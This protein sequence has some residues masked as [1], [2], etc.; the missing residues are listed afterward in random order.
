MVT[1]PET[2]NGFLTYDSYAVEEVVNY[3]AKEIGWER[4][5]PVPGGNPRTFQERFRH[6]DVQHHA[7]R[8]GYHE[9]EIGF[10]KVLARGGGGGGGG[11]APFNA[12]LDVNSL[13]H[14]VLHYA[15]PDSGTNHG[16]AM[17]MQCAELLGYTTR[18]QIRLV[19]G[20][21]ELTPSA[22]GWNSGLTTQ[23]Q[24]GALLNAAEKMKK[25]LVARAADGFEG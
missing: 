13:G 18:D 14:V 10:E 3:G 4:R 8:V 9:G 15:Q 21:S 1:M 6:C 12:V 25:D 17:A 19:W 5:N 23:L 7:G 22:P 16:T 2:E 20:D 11:G 24:G